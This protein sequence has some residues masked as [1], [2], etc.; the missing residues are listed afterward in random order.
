MKL[1]TIIGA[2]VAALVLGGFG[3][4]FVTQGQQAQQ[5]SFNTNQTTKKEGTVV[6]GLDPNYPPMEFT[7]AQS[8][9]IG[10][11]LDLMDAVFKKMDLPYEVHPIIWTKKEDLLNAGNIDVIWSGMNITDERKATME[12]SQP[13]LPGEQLFVVNAKT[14]INSVEQLAGTR[15][16]LQAGTFVLPDIEKLEQ[17]LGTQFESKQEYSGVATAMVALVTG[18]ADVVIAD[19]VAVRYH[20]LHSPGKFRILHEKLLET[21]GAGVAAKQGN[22]DLI[23]KIN[24]ALEATRADGSFQAIY[25][26]WF[27]A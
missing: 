9:I 14:A 5:A 24:A 12:M 19:G 10:F 8:K 15:V 27:G 3:Y 2:V 11:D 23:N 20:N 26:K 18:R 13:Y 25:N 1:R 22:T 16:A 21:E 17:R 7:D 6:V 4:W